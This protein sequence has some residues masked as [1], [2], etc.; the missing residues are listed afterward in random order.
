[1]GVKCMV[2]GSQCMICKGQAIPVKIS[3]RVNEVRGRIRSSGC[4]F[5]SINN[6]NCLSSRIR[7]S[8]RF[9]IA[10]EC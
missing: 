3:P 6:S 7:H 9:R 5:G 8:S 2:L 4:R 1:M 10:F